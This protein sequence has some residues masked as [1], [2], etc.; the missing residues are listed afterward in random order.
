MLSFLMMLFIASST[1]VLA[2]YFKI[3]LN[4]MLWSMRI[5]VFLIPIITYPIALLICKELQNSPEGGK[6]KRAN[7]VL[8][9]AEGAYTTVQAE[10]RPGDG[11]EELAAEPVP[12]FIDLDEDDGAESADG[13]VRRVER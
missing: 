7:V 4:L 5:L 1:D 13:G 12:T 11:H 9:S 3:S 2:N 10:S 8:R 6:R